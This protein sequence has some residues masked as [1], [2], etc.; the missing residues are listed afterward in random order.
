MNP[1]YKEAGVG[2][3]RGRDGRIYWTMKLGKN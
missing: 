2:A 3:V 1:A